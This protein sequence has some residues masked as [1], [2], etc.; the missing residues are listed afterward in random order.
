VTALT[1]DMKSIDSEVTHSAARDHQGWNRFWFC[2]AGA[3]QPLRIVR[4]GMA[5]MAFWYFASHWAD[6]GTWLGGEGILASASLARFLNDADLGGDVRW[7]LS[8]LYWVDSPLLLRGYLLLGMLLAVASVIKIR[9]RA[10]SIA[11]WLAVVWLANRTMM[12]AGLEELALCFG[13]A[14]LAIAPADDSLH[15]TGSLALRLIQLHV[16]LLIGVTGLT[17]LS[18]LI[19]W[20]G[21]GVLAVIAPV[22]NRY[23]DWAGRLSP[24]VYELLTHG[25]VAIALVVPIFLWFAGTRRAARVA[26]VLW[27][28]VLGVLS[29]QLLYFITVAVLLQ[30]FRDPSGGHSRRFAGKTNQ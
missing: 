19:W 3:Q 5:A 12:L 20:D 25:I 28:V 27:S 14:Y 1:A 29:S 22:E 17:M 6:I 26:A 13:L 7:R 2:A 9:T 24:P 15:W 21:S 10:I 4:T 11:L 16:S 18:S 8:P 23:I 30:S